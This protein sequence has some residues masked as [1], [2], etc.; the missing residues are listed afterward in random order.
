MMGVTGCGKTTIG[1][2]L[3]DRLGWE[4]LEGDT[5]HPAAN[6]AKM[7]G[8]TPLSD[9]D[10]VPWL[11]AIAA[12]MRGWDQAGQSGVV[13]CSALKRV[14]RNILVGELSSVRLAYLQGDERTV[15]GRLAVRKGHFMPPALLNSQFA[16]L[17]AP[18]AD[19]RP[20]IFPI[21]QSP[22]VIIAE[23]AAALS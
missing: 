5:L 8:G 18:G 9:T 10:R 22:S 11:H 20:L 14:Y 4:F 15:A 17:E 2:A 12:V 19:E 16:A 23:L 1:R 3:A 6:V 21:N 13:T 7:A